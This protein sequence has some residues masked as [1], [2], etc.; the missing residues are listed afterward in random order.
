M[1]KPQHTQPEKR[2]YFVM[3]NTSGVWIK[4]SDEYSRLTDAMRALERLILSY[5]F[6]RLGGMTLR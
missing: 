6:A 5:P 2:V 1:E 4:I 3:N